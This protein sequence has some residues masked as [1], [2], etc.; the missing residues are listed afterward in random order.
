MKIASTAKLP[1]QYGTFQI[2][3]LTNGEETCR[4]IVAVIKGDVA[5]KEKVLTRV[6]SQCLTGDTLCSLR[7]DCHAQ[8]VASLQ[9]IEGAGE[10]I[11]GLK[12][13]GIKIASIQQLRV[14]KNRWNEGYLKTKKEKL[15]QDL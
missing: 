3:G 11:A 12:T 5:G 13:H 2:V 14:G 10:G 1:S 7:C 4:E 8:L 9:L 15:G 6:H